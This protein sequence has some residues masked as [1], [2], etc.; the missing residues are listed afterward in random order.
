MPDTHPSAGDT[1]PRT[2]QLIEVPVSE[3]K[4]LFYAMDPSPSREEGFRSKR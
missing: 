2:C 3:L 4:Q 1:I